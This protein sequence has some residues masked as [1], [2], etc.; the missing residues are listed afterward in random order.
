MLFS[1]DLTGISSLPLLQNVYSLADE[2]QDLIN[3]F[4]PLW[5][6]SCGKILDGDVDGRFYGNSMTGTAS[7]RIMELLVRFTHITTYVVHY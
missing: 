2:R 1:L 5:C 4:S 3:P 7:T 6:K